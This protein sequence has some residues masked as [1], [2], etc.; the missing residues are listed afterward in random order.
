MGDESDR[1]PSV[2]CL[3]YLAADQLVPKRVSWRMLKWTK[4]PCKLVW[5]H[6]IR[7]SAVVLAAPLCNCERRAL[8]TLEWR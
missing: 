6:P 5:V 1:V 3:L 2:G 8:S 7:L 4:V